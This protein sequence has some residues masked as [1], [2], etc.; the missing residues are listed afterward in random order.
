MTSVVLVE[1]I[2]NLGRLGSVVNVAPGYAFNYLIP[3]KKAVIATKETIAQYDA[4]REE[5]EKIDAELKNKA[6]NLKN[7]IGARF[8]PIAMSIS[9]NGK[10]YGSVSTKDIATYINE[11][12]GFGAI[13]DKNKIYIKQ[14]IK[15]YGIFDAS[16]E[17]HHDVVLGFKI[18]VSSS[19]D[20]A[21]KAT[22]ITS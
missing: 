1:N 13:A 12:F 20:S 15:E 18:S 17:L 8:V 2:R 4:K 11:N 7:S 21:K 22:E 5:L 10:L 3:Q 14:S 19:I 16:L 9:E 6:I